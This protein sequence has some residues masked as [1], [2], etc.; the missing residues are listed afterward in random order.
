MGPELMSLMKQQAEKF[1]TEMLA[2]EVTSVDFSKRPFTVNV[3]NDTYT[4][5]AVIIASGAS[6]RMLGIESEKKLI[7]RGVSACATCD[8]FFFKNKE[9]AVIGGG[10]S[11]L[12]EATFLTNFASKVTIIH[13]RNEFRASKF[14]QEKTMKNP[15][16]NVIW[17][18]VVDEILG[19]SESGVRGL[20]LKNV[21][22]NQI[23]EFKCE[24]V[25]V[26]IGHEPNTKLFKG[27]LELDEKGYIVTHNGSKTS[28]EG[29][30][31][32]GDV[33]DHTYRQAITAAGSGCI[34]AID[35]ERFL[36]Q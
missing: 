32:A 22:T 15:K 33:Q 13:R 9:I 12:E 14:M 1:G 4:S 11:A 3:G 27:Q 36:A 2:D 28:V 10:D 6:A 30:F 29:V 18:S 7:G 31:A 19:T 26:A 35:A 24:G 5:D 23:T 16:I 17:D 25:F 8:G 20:K 34:S 21:K